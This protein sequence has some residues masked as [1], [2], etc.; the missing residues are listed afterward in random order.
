MAY[1]IMFW[2]VENLYDTLDDPTRSYN[3]FTPTGEARWTIDKYNRRLDNLSQVFSAI[4]DAHGG[5]PVLA[6]LS[7]VENGSVLKAL[8][9]RKRFSGSHYKYVHY[10]S[11]DARGVDC[12]L[13][14]RSD[15]FKLL[16]SEPV[17]LVLRSGRPYIG[18]DILAAWGTLDG[19]TVIV[20]VCHFLSRRGGV[21]ASAGFRRAGAETVRDHALEM[22]KTYPDAKIIIMGDMN[23]SPRDESL[24]ELLR[25]GRN[26][27]SIPPDEYF[28]P[29][30]QLLDEG[31]GTSVY[32]NRWVLYDNIIVSA[33]MIDSLPE[34]HGLH[35]VKCDKDHYGE[36][37]RRPFMLHK[38]H[39]RRAF[40]GHSFQDGFSDHLPVLIRISR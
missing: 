40:N 2:N 20:Y 21:N 8:T 23:D 13:L 10:E 3:A 39:P 22:R 30:W 33:N 35:I 24:A 26:I 36:I 25:A 27:H 1:T 12:G 31:Q 29:F 5:F 19:E 37:F 34:K 6:G 32:G 15:K 4:S 7:E 17:K 28:N 11:N 38:G 9:G 14:Y 16:G 18:R